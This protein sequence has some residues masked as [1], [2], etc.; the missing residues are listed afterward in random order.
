MRIG[1]PCL[2]IIQIVAGL[3]HEAAWRLSVQ[4]WEELLRE[5]CLRHTLLHQNVN[6]PLK[7]VA[8]SA[9]A[10]LDSFTLEER[11]GHCVA[12]AWASSSCQRTVPS[13]VCACSIDF[14]DN[15]IPL[16]HLDGETTMWIKTTSEHDCML[17]AQSTI[18][19]MLYGSTTQLQRTATY[20][21]S[22]TNRR[23]GIVRYVGD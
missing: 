17:L 21:I 9:F 12:D 16:L 2:R 8:P 5:I 18:H 10:A 1:F 23:D 4:C 14:Y 20:S 11:V 19:N 22:A 7:V 15:N 3:I 13:Q 6:E